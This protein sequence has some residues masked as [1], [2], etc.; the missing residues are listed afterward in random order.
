MMFFTVLVEAQNISVQN[1]RQLSNDMDARVNHPKTDQNGDKC[2][3]IKV[4]T[5]EQGF[6][7]EG[8]M[9]GIVAVEHKTAEYW[10]YIPHG[11]KRI[12]IKHPQLGILRNYKYPEVIKEA[13]VYELKLVIGQVET[14]IVPPEIQ[15]QWVIYNSDPSGADLYIDEEFK[16]KTPLT[17][18]QTLGKHSYRINLLN[19]HA[20]AGNLQLEELDGRKEINAILKPNFGSIIIS[21]IPEE[22]EAEIIIDGITTGRFT[23][24]TIHEI[25]SGKH[26]ISIRNEW[27]EPFY[28]TIL[29]EDSK[30]TQVQAPLNP[31]FGKV[32]IESIEGADIFINDEF[33]SNENWDGR[34]LSGLHTIRS[35]KLNYDDDIIKINVIKNEDLSIFLHPKAING[36]LKIK[37]TPHDSEIFLNNELIGIT[38]EVFRGQLIGKYGLV[39]KKEGYSVHQEEIEVFRDS[40]TEID[41]VLNSGQDVFI[42]SKPENCLVIINGKSMGTTPL[43][44]SLPFGQ[45][46]VKL[47]KDDFEDYIEKINVNDENRNFL[48]EM[49]S[50]GFAFNENAFQV[51]K[52][53]KNIFLGTTV[54][55]VSSS[56]YF[57]ISAQNNYDKYIDATT[58]ATDLHNKVKMQNTIWKVSAG[59]GIAS[60]ALSYMFYN[61]QKK[62]KRK[63]ELTMAYLSDGALVGAKINF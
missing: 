28:D 7:W 61:K 10:L 21:S 63:L 13:V 17:I 48:F 40:I 62:A 51:A 31:I 6:T 23:P 34:L 3:I 14:V 9:F 30:I 12:T 26:Q 27:Y 60:T 41:V 20:Y 58:E 32:T 8:D 15:S 46:V 25:S 36:I 43:N 35:S 2:A 4:L 52:R 57:Y 54:L 18:E 38:P 59:V 37:S 53:N 19:H 47:K 16:G 42:D 44:T 56:V 50:K 1:F 33:Q 49:K 11:A 24:D 29:I 5:T 39:I 45:N 55:A 22:E